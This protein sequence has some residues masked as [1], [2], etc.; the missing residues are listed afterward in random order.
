[1][2]STEDIGMEEGFTLVSSREL[3]RHLRMDYLLLNIC[4]SIHSNCRCTYRQNLN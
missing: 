3:Q 4:L 2:L 1:M